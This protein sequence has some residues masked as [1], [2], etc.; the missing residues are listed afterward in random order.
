LGKFIKWCL[1]RLGGITKLC[2]SAPEA[3]PTAVKNK[4]LDL[5]SSTNISNGISAAEGGELW[6]KGYIP[7]DERKSWE[8]I[9]GGPFLPPPPIRLQDRSMA[10]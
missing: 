3:D 6:T 4:V 2:G 5:H 10:L 9:R 1:N 7:L 8:R